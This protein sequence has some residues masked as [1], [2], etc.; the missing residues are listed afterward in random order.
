MSLEQQ[1]AGLVTAT[2]ALTQEVS[3]KMAAIT[4]TVDAKKGELDAWKANARREYPSVNLLANS[5]FQTD[6]NSDGYPDGFFSFYSASATPPTYELITPDGLAVAGSDAKIAHEL[7]A[8][9]VGV[10]FTVPSKVLKVTIPTSTTVGAADAW[11]LN[12]SLPI[13]RGQSSRGVYYYAKTAGSAAITVADQPGGSTGDIAQFNQPQ[14]AFLHADT[15]T[16]NVPFLLMVSARTAPLTL[17]LANPWL[18]A[19]YVDHA[20]NSIE[21]R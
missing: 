10:D 12:Q 1:I 3:G 5:R 2:N 19:G 15:G 20:P 16:S 7:V 13:L 8:F 4:Q 21:G 17:F 6:S 14:K 18:T 9:A 11:T